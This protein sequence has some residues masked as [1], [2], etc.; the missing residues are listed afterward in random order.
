MGDKMFFRLCQTV[1]DYGK[2]IPVGDD[3]FKHIDQ[4]KPYYQSIYRYS[5]EQVKEAQKIVEVTIRDK[6]T[7]KDKKIKRP[8]GISGFTDV[9]T[10]KLVFDFDSENIS[11]SQKDANE[12]TNRLLKQ[13]FKEEDLG[14]FFSGGKGFHVEIETDTLLTPQQAKS[15]ATS[16]A[17]GLK[18]FDSVV[19]NPSRIFRVPYTK[20]NSSGFY[21]TRLSLEELRESS[22]QEVQEIAKEAYEPEGLQEVHLPEGLLALAEKKE[23]V[24]KEEFS[25]ELDIDFDPLHNPL[26]LSN[27]KNALLQG[28][29]PPGQRSNGFMILTAT[30]RGKG[31]DQDLCYASLKSTIRK[32]AERYNQEAFSK[33]EF[34]ENIVSQVFSE[35]WQGGTFSE[36]NFPESIKGHLTD[37]GIPRITLSKLD[38]DLVVGVEEGLDNF[39]DYATRIDENRMEFG[40]PALDRLLKPQVGHFV[41]LLGPAGSGKTSLA[42]ELLSSM[43]KK[44]TKCYFGS[45]DMN[46]NILFQKLLQ[47]ETGMSDDDIYD[48]YRKK[49]LEQIKK[50]KAILKKHYSNVVFDFKV[51][52][53]I[54]GLKRSIAKKEQEI[55]EEVKLVV[56]DYIEL[57]MSD[58]S[59]ATQASAEAAQ[60][61]REIANSGKLVIVL[62]QPNKMSTKLDEAP[63]SYTAAKGSSAIAQA[64]TSMM[65]VFRPG[66][67]PEDPS[68]DKY[69]GIAILKNRM[70]PLG[71]CYFNWNGPRGLITEMEDIER[72]AL[73]EFLDMK[74]AQKGDDG[75]L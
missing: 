57:I 19:Y 29:I 14:I 33:T 7:G 63:K 2:Y 65:G 56:V 71:T 6:K 25:G 24:V 11:D 44:G 73:Q 21:K 27:W 4:N 32:Q 53:T 20:H 23:E 35:T 38:K 8:R 1:Q 49:D 72:V 55:G 17:K 61:L 52:S 10:K 26:G 30:L 45:Y 54:E 60:G 12:I 37:L 75:L 22:V 62:L 69:Y 41:G 9:V 59:D 18:T 70:G 5:E 51:G 58:K 16:L 40:I 47:R 67:S 28:F 43:S 31:F 34:Y 66:Y 3:I 46:S 48:V 36:D 74:K 50:F 64:V 15:I 68:M 13:G 39:F 42:L